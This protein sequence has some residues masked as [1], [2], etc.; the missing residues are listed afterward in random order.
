MD[1]SLIVEHIEAV[2]VED[3]VLEVVV[4]TPRSSI[5]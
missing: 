1:R 5:A 2:E 4:T 3:E